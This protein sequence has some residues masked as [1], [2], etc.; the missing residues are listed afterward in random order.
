MLFV[1]RCGCV[2]RI[3]KA[4]NYSRVYDSMAV[5]VVVAAAVV[6]VLGIE[7]KYNDGLR[8]G[9]NLQLW[10]MWICI[11]KER[12]KHTKTYAEWNELCEFHW[13]GR[14]GRLFIVVFMSCSIHMFWLHS[15]SESEKRR[16]KHNW[17]YC[18]HSALFRMKKD[19]SNH[20][21]VMIMVRNNKMY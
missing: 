17:K 15:K 5:A 13:C 16:E 19:Y 1:C 11:W 4:I 21:R 10:E 20:Y 7:N 8:M 14:C 2:S 6:Q 12:K 9:A 18:T 3:R